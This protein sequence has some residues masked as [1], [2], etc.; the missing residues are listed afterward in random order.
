MKA[1]EGLQAEPYLP[2]PEVLRPAGMVEGSFGGEVLRPGEGSRYSA[3]LD[4]GLLLALVCR[5]LETSTGWHS[6]LVRASLH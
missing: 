5:A 2:K 4:L 1:L 3:E 6:C